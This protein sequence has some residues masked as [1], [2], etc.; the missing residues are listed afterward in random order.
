MNRLDPEILLEVLFAPAGLALI[1][2][3]N[4]TYSRFDGIFR[5][6]LSTIGSAFVELFH[7]VVRFLHFL[8]LFKTRLI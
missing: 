6:I 8:A 3:V 7:P 2:R 5:L 1:L 4:L